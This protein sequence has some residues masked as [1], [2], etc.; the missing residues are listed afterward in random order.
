MVP[1]DG[2]DWD[3]DIVVWVFIVDSWE[4]REAEGGRGRQRDVGREGERE[5]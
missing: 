4:P 2:E 3:G 1:M 5:W